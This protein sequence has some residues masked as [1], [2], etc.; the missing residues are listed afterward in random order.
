MYRATGGRLFG[1]MGKNP[2]LLLNTVGR[3]SG[4]KRAN[5]LLYVVDGEDFV[6]IAS[7]GGAPT[8]PAWYL[9][10]VANPDTTVEVGDRELRI[11]AE[12]VDGEEKVRLWRKMAEMYPTYDDYQKKTKRE[13]P[14]L[15][16]HTRD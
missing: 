5:P 4:K 12:E 3:K 10:L 6:I 2:L 8:H 15:V 14:L 1:R 16:L 7:K 13:I 9:N 11:S